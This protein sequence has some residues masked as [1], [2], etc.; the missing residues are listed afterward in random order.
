M[1]QKANS[2]PRPP[3]LAGAFFHS[4]RQWPEAQHDAAVGGGN[5]AVV[6]VSIAAG[7]GLAIFSKLIVRVIQAFCAVVRRRRRG[8]VI[9]KGYTQQELDAFISFA[10]EILPPRTDSTEE[11]RALLIAEGILTADGE[12][13]AEYRAAGDSSKLHE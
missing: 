6:A 2:R 10:L 12:L 7:S 11:A 4:A 1:V 8:R 9:A 13:A 5:L 3:S